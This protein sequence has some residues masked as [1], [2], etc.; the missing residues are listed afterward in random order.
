[1][2]DD[3]KKAVARSWSRLRKAHVHREDNA[4]AKRW[5]EIGES[6]HLAEAVAATYRR[7]RRE[8]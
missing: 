1:M 8:A 7:R 2:S 5:N 6:N 4:G 3:A